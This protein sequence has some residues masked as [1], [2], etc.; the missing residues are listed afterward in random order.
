MYFRAKPATGRHFR[1]NRC[2]YTPVVCNK[3]QNNCI[4]RLLPNNALEYV[5]YINKK[6]KQ[7]F[8]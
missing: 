8:N 5:K 7:N 4:V 6:S 2:T 1:K 3:Q